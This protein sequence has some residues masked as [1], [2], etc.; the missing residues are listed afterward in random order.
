MPASADDAERDE[1]AEHQEVAMRKI[2]DAHD[3]EHEIEA[4]ADQAEIQ[5]EQNAGDERVNQ[6]QRVAPGSRLRDPQPHHGRG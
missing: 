2:D 4:D 1:G 3:A 5:P 6:H